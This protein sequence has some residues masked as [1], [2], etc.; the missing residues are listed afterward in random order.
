RAYLVAAL[1][2]S[3]AA[4][5][6][7]GAYVIRLKEAAR[8]D[9]R[10]NDVGQNVLTSTKLVAA[11]G[12]VLHDHSAGSGQLS[13]YRGTVLKAARPGR[14]RPARLRREYEKATLISG[15]VPETLPY[16]GKTVLIERQS[17]GYL[18]AVEGG[19][20]LTGAA[21]LPLARE[22][23]DDSPELQQLI[24]PRAAVRL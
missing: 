19:A 24:L 21:A 11:D 8:G 6:A 18:F 15:G 7:P 2:T 16:Q 1:L 23:G 10:R 14:A 17:D 5:Q 9:V 22:F 4:A 20:A 13:V 12:R 3:P